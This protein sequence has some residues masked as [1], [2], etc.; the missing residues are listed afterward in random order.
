MSQQFGEAGFS[1]SL[2]AVSEGSQFGPGGLI[3]A[4]GAIKQQA[5]APKS[6]PRRAGTG[7]MGRRCWRDLGVRSTCILVAVAGTGG[8]HLSEPLLCVLA[9]VGGGGGERAEFSLCA[10]IVAVAENVGHLLERMCRRYRRGPDPSTH[11]GRRSGPGWPA[12]ARA[13]AG[14]PVTVVGGGRAAA[15]A[16]VSS[17]RR[18]AA[19]ATRRAVPGEMTR[20]VTVSQSAWCVGGRQ[21]ARWL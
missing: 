15:A 17:P 16:T 21:R 2:S 8:Q 7:R 4:F 14:G 5:G 9:A 6:V 20:V 11:P 13:L 19:C 10:G 18:S 3:V 1:K 12:R